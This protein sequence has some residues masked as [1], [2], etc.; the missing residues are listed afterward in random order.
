MTDIA[1]D[2]APLASVTGS[3]LSERELILYRAL[4]RIVRQ[5]AQGY[6]VGHD[7]FVGGRSALARTTGRTGETINWAKEKMP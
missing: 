5:N 6:P 1:Q 4:L 3:A 2:N 7:A